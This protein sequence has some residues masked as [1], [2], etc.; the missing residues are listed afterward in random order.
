MKN[1]KL[2]SIPLAGHMKLSKKM[3]PTAREEKE[4]MA[5]V[6]YSSIVEREAISWQ[7]KLKKCVALSTTEAE[8][9]AASEAGKEIIWLKRFLQELGLRSLWII[10]N[11][12]S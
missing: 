5:K 8:Y 12:E 2:V 6:P 1:A 11:L 4:N 10:R 9:I 3:C 7:S